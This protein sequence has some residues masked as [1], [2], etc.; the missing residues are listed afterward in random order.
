MNQ[1]I[2]V[3]YAGYTIC[4]TPIQSIDRSWRCVFVIL[5]GDNILLSACTSTACRT[6]DDAEQHGI[7]VGVQ[8]VDR[9]ISESSN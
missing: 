6:R 4:V 2:R 1:E 7:M 8:V 9:E 3:H 5:E